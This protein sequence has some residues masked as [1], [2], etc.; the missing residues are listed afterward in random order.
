[1]WLIGS[2]F[3]TLTWQQ[4]AIFLLIKKIHV[5]MENGKKNI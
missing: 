5:F 2:W 3:T 4:I 1:M